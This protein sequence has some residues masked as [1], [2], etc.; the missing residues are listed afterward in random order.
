MEHHITQPAHLSKA[1]SFGPCEAKVFIEYEVVLCKE[2][3][4]KD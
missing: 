2:E 3:E 1:G 4:E